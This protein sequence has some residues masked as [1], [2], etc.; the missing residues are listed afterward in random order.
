MMG[1]ECCILVGPK[2]VCNHPTNVAT[3]GEAW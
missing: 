2:Q 3:I 1:N